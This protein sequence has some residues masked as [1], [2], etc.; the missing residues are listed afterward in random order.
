MKRT[1]SVAMPAFNEASNLDGTVGDVIAAASDFDDYE[2]LIVN[3]G[4]TDSTAE[5]ADRLARS[6]GRV[7]VIHHPRNL[8]FAAAYRSALSQARMI[9]FTFVPGDREVTAESVR[10]VL[11]AVGAA[12]LVVPYH[13]TPWRRQ[14]YRRVL[15]RVC[16]MEINLL[17][18][19][20]L[21]YYQGPVVYPTALARRLPRSCHGF[22][23]ATEMLVHALAGGHTW[24]EVGIA[25]QERTYGRS[26]AVGLANIGR[27]ELT[28]LRLWWEV[29]AGRYG[30]APLAPSGAMEP[31]GRKAI[32]E[33]G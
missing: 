6:T 14:W 28:I 20:H 3:D 4:S 17:F 10:N 12:D 27:A 2:I 22:F 21:R 29:R 19:W 11:A 1:I 31:Q 5:V 26:K 23:F 24:V 9:Y 7:S 8:G 33:E 25:H 13:A 30:A 16:T 18:G 15:T 32:S